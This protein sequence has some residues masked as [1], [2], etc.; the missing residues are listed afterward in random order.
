M[1]FKSLVLISIITLLTVSC[2]RE[3]NTQQPVS[4]TEP[5]TSVAENTGTNTSQTGTFRRAEHETRGNVKVVTENGRRYLQ[6]DSSFKT[7]NG[8][9]LFV[10]LYR[11]DSVPDSGIKGKDYVRIARLQKTSGTQRYAIP[12]NVNLANFQSV[13]VWCRAFNSTFGYAPLSI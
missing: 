12:D 1:K 4:E 11:N 5:T 6:F 13:A 2:A 10:I 8:P 3:T 7:D 9:D